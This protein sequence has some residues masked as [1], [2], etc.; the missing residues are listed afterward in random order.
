MC[1]SESWPRTDASQNP[2]GPD[3]AWPRRAACRERWRRSTW[4]ASSREK[5]QTGIR[6]EEAG[7]GKCRG[8]GGLWSNSVWCG[9][10]YRHKRSPRESDGRAGFWMLSWRREKTHQ[11]H[12]RPQVAGRLD[13]HTHDG[14]DLVNV[15]VEVNPARTEG[16][17]GASTM[18]AWTRGAMVPARTFTL[19]HV[20]GTRYKLFPGR[21][22]FALVSHGS[23]HQPKTNQT[24]WLSQH[25]CREAGPVLRCERS[26]RIAWFT[27]RSL[28]LK[29]G[30][31]L[32]FN[33]RS[34]FFASSS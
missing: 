13:H 24:T 29:I 3:R 20:P 8:R 1:R 34:Q 30:R 22:C 5:R 17:R 25:G 19:Q 18:S 32:V 26:H 23:S 2:P 12:H 10:N 16:R 6:E 27:F 7:A 33:N 15:W 9:C 4:A 21:F 11:S 31:L 28:K 14:H